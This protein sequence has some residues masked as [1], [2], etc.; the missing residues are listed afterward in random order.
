M[1]IMPTRNMRLDECVCLTRAPSVYPV[2]QWCAGP[3]LPGA[4]VD[5]GPPC[6]DGAFRHHYSMTEM[7][8]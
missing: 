7:V 6:H 2:E 8:T 4:L 1:E 5:M 3:L